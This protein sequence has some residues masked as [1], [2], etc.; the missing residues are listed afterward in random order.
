MFENILVI[1]AGNICRSPYAAGRLQRLMPS[2]TVHS[3][4]L[5][6]EKSGLVGA[7]ASPEGQAIARSLG[8]DLTDHQAQQINPAMVDACDLILAMNQNQIDML[9]RMFP[10]ARH[11][12]MLFGHWIGISQIDDPYQKSSAIFQQVYAVLDRA[13]KAWSDKIGQ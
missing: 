8:I 5:L 3:A 9:S 11:K 13:A 4:G 1:C 6:T 10:K 12:T 2:H 7:S